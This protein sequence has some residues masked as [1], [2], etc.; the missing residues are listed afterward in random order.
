MIKTYAADILTRQDVQNIIDN[1]KATYPVV[2]NELIPGVMKVGEIQKVLQN[3][4]REEISIKNL[5]LILETLGDNVLATKE[6]GFLT[7]QVKI[8]LAKGICEEY[9]DENGVISV[10]TLSP[11]VESLILQ[12]LSD[13]SQAETFGA[14]SPEI[15]RKIYTNLT[16]VVEKVTSMGYQAVVICSG[17]VRLPFKRLT[18]RVIRKLVVLSYNEID[19]DY[20]IEAVGMLDIDALETGTADELNIEAAMAR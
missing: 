15:L 16:K 2:I 9:K 19:Y 14:L 1:L 7:N 20:T 4:L 5:R 12:A 10:I 11:R 8:A 18:E 13:S 3:L 17:N 6:I